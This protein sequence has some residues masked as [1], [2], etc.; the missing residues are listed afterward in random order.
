MHLIARHSSGSRIFHGERPSGETAMTQEALGHARRVIELA[1][2]QVFDI[3]DGHLAQLS[4][5]G[6]RICFARQVA[7]Y[8]AHVACRMTLTEVGRLFGRD[9][10]TV[11]HACAVVEDRRD[12]VALDRAL[13]LLEWAVPVMATR[14]VCYLEQFQKH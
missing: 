7:M 8:L 10:T 4:R 12:E 11:A 3:R 9:R 5:S 2:T 1:V 13:D 6:A 14:P